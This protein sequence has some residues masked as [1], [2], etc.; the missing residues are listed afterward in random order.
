MLT[1]QSTEDEKVILNQSFWNGRV[2]FNFRQVLES[3][4]RVAQIVLKF[5]VGIRLD[6]LSND[7]GQFT[8]KF[9]DLNGQRFSLRESI[10]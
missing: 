6:K 9:T 10:E 3:L 8:V 4:R 5:N 7:K 1:I 2:E